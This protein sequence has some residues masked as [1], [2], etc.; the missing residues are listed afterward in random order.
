MK[1]AYAADGGINFCVSGVTILLRAEIL[2][3]PAFQ[4]AFT[5][6]MWRGHRQNTGD[7][8][9]ITRWILFGHLFQTSQRQGDGKRQQWKLG[10]Q[11]TEAAE[12]GTSIMPD[13]NFVGQLKRWY[14]SGLRH[15]LMCLFY[16]PGLRAMLQTCPFMAR[17]M[18]EGMLN[19]LLIWIRIYCLFLT[20]F[21]W[22]WMWF[23]SVA[24]QQPSSLPGTC[25]NLC[26]SLVKSLKLNS[27]ANESI[28]FFVLAFN[29]RNYIHGFADF[30]E[31]HPYASKHWLAAII[32]DRIYLISDW[33]CWITLSTEGW[34][35]R[36]TADDDAGRGVNG[37][38]DGG[39]GG[40]DCDDK[41]QPET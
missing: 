28:R 17:K 7:D 21:S 32:V 6:D 5:N 41:K 27:A 26:Y 16:E 23:G 34:L 20:I 18:V 1:A 3:D 12:V 10:M 33:Y 40:D 11:L 30:F 19:P 13:A 25:K 2:R 4:H 29:V 37:G 8:T 39:N 22:K 31:Q 35:T 9:F 24:T 36:I 15:R 14:R 38:V